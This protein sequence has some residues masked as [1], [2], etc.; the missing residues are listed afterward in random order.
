M[1]KLKCKS[2]LNIWYIDDY[3]LNDQNYC[4]CCCAKITKEVSLGDIDTPPKAIYDY[5]IQYGI[6]KLKDS[7]SLINY[8]H[9]MCPDMKKE[10]RLLSRALRDY[11]DEIFKL[12]NAEL[13]ETDNLL[14]SLKY[15][16]IN[17]DEMS[18]QGADIIC[19]NLNGAVML[20]KGKNLPVVMSVEVSD[21]SDIS[22]ETESKTFEEEQPEEKA[23]SQSEII[24]RGK[25]GENAEWTLYRNGTLVISGLG[26]MYDYELDI[27]IP[28]IKLG[29]EY[30][31]MAWHKADK[32]PRE[33][34]KYRICQENGIRLLRLMEKPPENGI[35]LTADESLTIID[36]PMYEKK[37]L[38]KVI[39]NLL[40]KI[41]PETNPWTR[42]EPVFHSRVDINLDRDEAEIRKYMT[43]LGKESFADKYPQLAKEWHP[44]KNGSLTPDKVKPRS[45]ISVW[46]TC[47]TCGHDYYTTVGHRVEGTGCPRCGVKKV[48]GANRKK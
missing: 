30:D 31:G 15:Q 42:R 44:T 47:P 41:D 14:N 1:K 26:D 19:E 29:I 8:L 20:Y 2:C 35:L 5:I 6:D 21:V 40:D 32:L 43:S 37:H 7:E 48:L 18:E 27:Y 33:K 12:F 3:R 34:K 22:E 39:R 16:F 38:T 28:S 25:C 11:R 46:W 10:L 24:D 13:S 45:N 23:Y 9:D 36:G 4:P 17:Y